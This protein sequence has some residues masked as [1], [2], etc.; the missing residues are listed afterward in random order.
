MI[1][2]SRFVELALVAA[3]IV[4][5]QTASAQVRFPGTP[6]GSQYP[7]V[8]A[9]QFDV[10]APDVARLRHEDLTPRIGP[11]R[12]G[13]VLPIYIDLT[14]DGAYE[15]TPDDRVV[16]RVQVKALGAHSLGFEFSRFE[17]PRG[18]QLYVYDEHL[19]NVFG[20]YEA[21]NEIPS[22]GE[23]VI[24]PFPG[25]TAILEYSQPLSA[26]S[27][28]NIVIRS[29]IYDYKNVFDLERQLDEIERGP[30]GGYKSACDTID[31]NCPE[32]DP[33]PNQ[34]RA[35]VRT[36]FEGTLCSATLINNT[37][38]DGTPYVYTAQHCSQGSTTVFRFN[39]QNSGCNTNDA[40]TG[41]TV[42][43]A[44]ALAGGTYSDNRLLRIEAAIPSS[45]NPY[46]AG[47]NRQSTNP[48]FGM[49]MHHPS[50]GPKKISIDG[51][52]GGQTTEYFGDPINAYVQCW[53][54]H[55]QNG[56]WYPGSS[57]SPLFDENNLVRGALTG[58]PPLDYCTCY[59]GR[60]QYFWSNTLVAQ[61]LDPLDLGSLCCDGFD[62]TTAPPPPPPKAPKITSI[63]PTSV[64]AFGEKLVTLT[65]TGF[66]SA[67][68]VTVGTKQLTNPPDGFQIIDPCTIKFDPPNPIALGDVDVTVTNSV[69]TSAPITLTYKVTEPLEM[70][71][72]P[73]L[74]D[75]S[76]VKWSWGGAPNQ[77][78]LFNYSLTP[79][80]LMFNGQEFLIY[81]GS[82]A[83]GKTNAAGLGSL[84]VPI[85]GVPNGTI[86]F[87]QVLTVDPPAY[88]IA[89][90]KLSNIVKS[91]AIGGP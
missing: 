69:G 24:E 19:K 7:L 63:S 21:V 43:G 17:L 35:V 53:D 56:G 72:P 88:S 77:V 52:G 4:S 29:V 31:V 42:S 78:T 75:G 16:F 67:T 58:G 41:Q 18:G 28:G 5:A 60:L 89:T 54:I 10:P 49:G 87:T 13:V 34:K 91:K 82:F 61:W 90:V 44:T 85:S 74:I 81:L 14:S 40:P 86:I 64:E 27:V 11:L 55:F 22:T 45:Y 25:D 68:I 71:G 23:F 36:A 48:T 50:G 38:N 37:A 70:D 76:I 73:L 79:N 51:N 62:P 83:V 39:Y 3:A 12:F 9:T 6:Q 46:F 80:T 59:Y 8:P 20:A 33:F 2:T 47:W 1:R 57:G 66:S 84:T 65:G 32:G 15:V 30:P 26:T